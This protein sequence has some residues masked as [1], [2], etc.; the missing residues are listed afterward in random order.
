MSWRHWLGIV[1]GAGVGIAIAVAL[2][3]YSDY[4][5]PVVLEGEGA[6]VY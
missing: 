6:V 1:A 5:E 3:R 2:H 4:F